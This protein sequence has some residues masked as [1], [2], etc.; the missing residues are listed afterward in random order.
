MSFLRRDKSRLNLRLVHGQGDARAPAPGPHDDPPQVLPTANGFP[1]GFNA[2]YPDAPPPPLVDGHG[3]PL[4]PVLDNYS[5]RLLISAPDSNLP[6]V[7]DNYKGFHAN[8]RPQGQQNVPPL[9]RPIK[10]RFKKK[11]TLLLGKWIYLLRK[12]LSDSGDDVGGGGGGSGSGGKPRLSLTA[13]VA[14]AHL[15]QLAALLQQLTGLAHAKLRIP[16]MLLMFHLG[17]ELKLAPMAPAALATLTALA[18][19]ALARFDL[20]LD[21]MLGIVDDAAAAMPQA[22]RKLVG[23]AAHSR[24]SVGSGG[25]RGGSAGSALGASG[26]RGLVASLP[27]ITPTAPGLVLLAPPET[28]KRTLTALASDAKG[29]ALRRQGLEAAWTAPELWDVKATPEPCPDDGEVVPEP[30]TELAPAPLFSQLKKYSPIWGIRLAL[31]VE[32]GPNN[33]IRVFRED[34]TFTTILCPLET[35]TTELLAII[36]RKFFLELVA[37]FQVS[38]HV[39]THFKVM[40]PFEK[41]LKVQ[42]GLLML[43][44]YTD[45]E[46]LKI[47]G[48]E[49]LLFLV[50]FVV[51]SIALR[52][53]TH[54]EE[55]VLSKDYVDVNL[56]GLSL[57]NIPIIFH[58]HTY[59]IEKLN[60]LNNP[61]I[62]IPL[63][64]I[65]L[66]NNLTAINSARNGLLRFPHNLLEAH[67]LTRLDLEL[68][69]LDELPREFGRL[70]L[71]THLKVNLNQLV[72][73]PP[74]FGEL[75]RLVQLNLSLNYFC[76]Y[77]EVVNTL[78]LLVDL[79][80]S[81][82]D[83]GVI[84]TLIAGLARLQ[85]FN[86]CTNKL[87]GAL[88]PAME[89]LILLKRLDIRYNSIT[90]VDVLGKLPALEVA[91][92]SKNAINSFLDQME[93]LRLLHFDR[94][95]IT[96][97]QF[98]HTLSY[99]T[100]LDLSKAKLTMVPPEFVSRIPHVEK[101]V[102]DKNHLVTLPDEIGHLHRLTLLSV[103]SN[104]LRSLPA[105]I[106]DLQQLQVLD[107]HA[108]NLQLLPETLWHLGLLQV[109]NCALNIIAGFPKP[110]L[111]VAKRVSAGWDGLLALLAS[112][113]LLADSLLLLTMVDNRLGDECW[114]LVLFL[115][116]LKYL[117]LLYNELSEI[118]EG[119][120]TRLS[121]LHELLVLGN[122]LTTLPAD[123]LELL[124]SLRLLHLNNNKLVALPAEIA[125]LKQLQHLDVGLNQLKYNIAN[126]PY[127]W[128]WQF[129]PN[130]RSLNFLGNKRFEIKQT[131][132]KNPD[133]GEYLDSLLALPKLRVLGLVDVTI[134]TS[135]VPD[136]LVETRVR[137]QSLEVALIG[138]GV[139]D[140][141][142]TR[143]HVLMGD[144][145]VQKFRGNDLEVLFCLLD[146][147]FGAVHKGH[148]ILYL[149]KT[150]FVPAFTAELERLAGHELPVDALRRA[151]LAMNKEINGTLAA[152]RA[153][154][155][156]SP[157]LADLSVDEDSGAG[158][159][160][161]VIYLVGKQLYLANVGDY[162]ALLLR[163]NGDHVFLTTKHDPT[164]RDEFER[165]RASGGY[166]LGSGLLN[167]QLSVLRGVGF[168]NYVPHTH[169]GPS[170]TELTLLL[171]DDTIVLGTK[172]LWDHVPYELAVDIIRQEKSDPMLA[173]QRLRDYAIAYG[174]V[175]K[176]LV[177]VVQ[178]GDAK[179]KLRSHYTRL[180][181]ENELVRRRKDR[182]TGDSTLRRLDDE[183]D[184]P[185]G[186][187]ALVFTDIKL[188]TWL[189]DTYPAPMRLAIKTHNTIMRRQ[190]RI[191][192]GYE[193]KTEGDAF[194]VSFPTPLSALLWCFNVQQAL[195]LA[196]WPLEILDT[197]QC[198]EVT[199][200][201]G[202]VLFRGLSV[203][204][205]IHWGS[206][207]C[208]PDVITGRMDYFGP[209]VNRALRISAIAD[210]GQISVLEDFVEEMDTL[211]RLHQ[212]IQEGKA[213]VDQAFG[214][215]HLADTIDHELA[216]LD[217]IGIKYYGLGER[218]LKGLETPENINLAYANNLKLRFDIF[219]KRLSQDGAPM[220]LRA[221][222]AIPVESIYSLRTLLLRLENVCACADGGKSVL[223][224]FKNSLQL[225]Q[226]QMLDSFKEAE[227]VELFNHLV[228]RVE[229]CVA[230]LQLRQLLLEAHDKSGYIDF[231]TLATPMSDV[232]LL[233]SD[234]VNEF[235]QLKLASQ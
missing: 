28:T 159:S 29:A 34:N 180:P 93:Q 116:H 224:Q 201:E 220:G 146:G 165:I 75:Q 167:G 95:P 181:V 213:A 111:A 163:A 72:L 127:D 117:N 209:M 179:L 60:V 6:G 195:L 82:N 13:L 202:N 49:D 204:M 216:Q 7:K 88:P 223:E 74:S 115:V 23:L 214:D 142:G 102:L 15:A 178:L 228:L 114:E 19:L 46:N 16:L 135:Q 17:L 104:N 2:Q 221:V 24:G 126:W 26:P 12:D 119:A 160:L 143:D 122:Q 61:G 109:L 173:A 113:Q 62:H 57:K 227:M 190:L 22:P 66:C 20:N 182:I 42:R 168:L 200:S 229:N 230:T 83:L 154:Q 112:P 140:F 80:L 136:Q 18:L 124:S 226:H 150:M 141:M 76:E 78:G 63:D 101:V 121:H 145:F 217:L 43:S 144:L 174:A 100:I 64:F 68:N 212:E 194:M 158:V 235:R 193:V 73:L 172:G 225:I 27:Q 51:E 25:S 36:R 56:L 4:A 33:I 32:G 171:G 97:L 208:E 183:I 162:E 191:V 169:A 8:K 5:P 211:I 120:L 197:D 205:G 58:Q 45:A 125:A 79:D 44:G 233:L 40:D 215:P 218:K 234:L 137:L 31:V 123:D 161:T 59:E 129:N 149:V 69:F 1:P 90:N 131:Y 156:G 103:H 199:D 177:T 130:L 151:F 98:I 219:Q 185:V 139:S 128:N 105:L 232:L 198:C 138:Y 94:N 189:W 152:K 187:L 222:G 3:A 81:Y 77:P 55:V 91:Y 65:Q 148:R 30:V 39:G 231:S 71:L 41:P 134:T 9:L 192:G 203:R 132:V 107:V 84:P 153:G 11:L 176:V 70:K 188:L 10:P 166:V 106:G 86:L 67:H 210:G 118:P 53:L 37:N 96:T 170:I 110:P 147:K 164:T 133:T 196:D 186:E 52:N 50:K 207:V 87:Q 38:A 206:P 99:L 48:R 157:G 184:P 85:K 108:N 54:D 14:L 89:G 21:E 175:D 47:L 35:T 92:A 155:P